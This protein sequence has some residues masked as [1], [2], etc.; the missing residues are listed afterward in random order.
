M[1]LLMKF[2][3]DF[4]STTIIQI[5]NLLDAFD[6]KYD[7]L[8]KLHFSRGYD[9]YA[10]HTLKNYMYNC[11]LSFKISKTNYLFDDL[12]KDMLE[13]MNI[14]NVTGI[15]NFY[16]Y[17]KAIE[18]I[19]QLVEKGKELSKQTLVKYLS[20]LDFYLNKC[21]EAINWCEEQ[22]F[23]PVQ[24]VYNDSISRVDDFGAVLIPSTFCRPIN[25]EKRR[26]IL[27]AHKTHALFLKNELSLREEREDIESIK[28]QIDKSHWKN[29]ELLSIF[30]AIITFLF[31]TV[32]FMANGSSMTITQQI[33]N[34]MTIGLV[35]LLFVCAIAV[36]TMQRE[37]DPKKYWRHPRLYFLIA[38]III[39]LALL[40]YILWTASSL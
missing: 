38:S 22:R 2:Y 33:Y 21:E 15:L 10:L 36:V 29:I 23:I 14:Q 34:I 24:N 12:E 16:P 32:N 1:A 26:H 7:F 18:F 13:I 37:N 5:D 20:R 30:T 35:L 39:F 28:Q 40:L 25:Y 27:S 4:P 8:Y 6:K 9:I 17:Q 3:K 31:G 19:I 11:R